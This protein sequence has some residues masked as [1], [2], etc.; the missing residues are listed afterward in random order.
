MRAYLVRRLLSLIPVL[1][2]ITLLVF[3]LRQLIPGDPATV[4][5]GEQATPEQVAALRTRLRLD[6]PLPLQYG[7]FLLGLLHLDLGQSLFTGVP[8]SQELRTFFPATLELAIAAMT[9][10]LGLGIPLGVLA[11]THK[12]GW[13]D[14]L[15]ISASLLGVSQPVYWLGLVLIYVFA[16]QGQ[17]LPPSGRLSLEAGFSFQPIT[18]LY[19]LDSLLRLDGRTL[20]DALRHLILPAVTLGTIPLASV[21]RISRA[22]MLEVLHQ[23]YIRTARA[24]GLPEGL[25]IVRHG[26][27]NALMPITTIAGLQFGKLLGGAILTETIFAWPGMG[28]WLY[29]GI[30][31]RDYPVV[32]GGALFVALVFVGVNVLVDLAYLWIDPRVKLK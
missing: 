12:N 22:A 27:R 29:D 24:K 3:A 18:G 16:V 25:V 5:L 2:G 9:L 26:L 1:V 23:D 13:W 14:Y 8:I 6:Q 15:V 4:M 31:Q 30:L 21:A 7:A 20:L 11:A 17:W 19:V 28:H 32:Q 10:A